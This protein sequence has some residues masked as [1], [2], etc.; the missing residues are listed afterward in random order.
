MNK[1]SPGGIL[2]IGFGILFIRLAWTGRIGAVWTALMTGQG[3]GNP[4]TGPEIDP[5]KRGAPNS[6]GD[7]TCA[8]E[9]PYPVWGCDGERLCL[10]NKERERPVTCQGADSNLYY[11]TNAAG[12]PYTTTAGNVR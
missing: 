2:L 4:P 12:A 11:A 6:A 8:K 5:T 9:R 1:G 7:W 3:S 10:T